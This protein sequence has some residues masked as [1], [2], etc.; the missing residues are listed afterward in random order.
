MAPELER[1]PEKNIQRKIMKIMKKIRAASNAPITR[2]IV[3]RTKRAGR[4]D[5]MAGFCCIMLRQPHPRVHTITA[6][7]QMMASVA[8]DSSYPITGTMIMCINRVGIVV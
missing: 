7:Q 5:V 1:R 4:E 8:E 2:A 3:Q 6:N